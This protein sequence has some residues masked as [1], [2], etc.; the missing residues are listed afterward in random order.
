MSKKESIEESVFCYQKCT[1]NN[2][3]D[4]W[5]HYHGTDADFVDECEYCVK[6]LNKDVEERTCYQCVYVG[7]VENGLSEDVVCKKHDEI[8]NPFRVCKN[9]EL[10][11]R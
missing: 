5:C 3:Y 8:V 9:F 7:F 4:G 10:R 11:T 6:M 1:Y 2:R